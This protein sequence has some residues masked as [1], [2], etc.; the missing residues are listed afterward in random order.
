M[1]P[2][3]VTLFVHGIGPNP[4]KVAILL[5]ELNVEYDAVTKELDDSP[6]GIKAPNFLKINPNGRLPALI[7][8][9]NNNHIVWESGAI[10]L[11]VAERFD[12][13]HK[14]I[15]NTLEERSEVWEWLF[16]QV[17]GLGPS[18]GQV[19]WFLRH[20][21][22][23]DLHPSVLERYRTETYRIYGILEERLENNKWVA[24]GRF[25]VADMANYP[26]LNNIGL[27]DL[28][29]A[30]YPKLT[31]YYTRMQMRHSIRK[32]YANIVPVHVTNKDSI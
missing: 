17:S 15:G 2:P 31:E 22:I 28:S 6:N 4:L 3:K 20:H 24:L 26:W 14:Y 11:Y 32:A 19:N 1:P 23:K 13:T 27:S 10:L 29:L 21:P 9:T 12:N 5:E 7:D 18:Q 30:N 8:H 16:L 25:T